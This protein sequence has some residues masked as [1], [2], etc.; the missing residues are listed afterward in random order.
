[1]VTIVPGVALLQHETQ[2]TAG[3]ECKI[4][5]QVEL[6]PG[7]DSKAVTSENVMEYIHR[8]AN[9]RLNFQIK[10]GSEAFWRGFYDLV[11]QDWVTMF[12]EEEIQMLISGGGEGLDVADMQAHV[13]YAGGYHEEHPV[14]MDFW[15]VCHA[16]S[17]SIS[18]YPHGMLN[19]LPAHSDGFEAK[20]PDHADHAVLRPANLTGLEPCSQGDLFLNSMPL[21]R[22]PL[23]T[24][25][26]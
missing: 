1:M 8:V 23:V 2:P 10:A 22:L 6:V 3:R 24:A 19:S 14:I 9:Y 17:H 21:L 16:C 18:T 7:G 26:S 12:S 15:K 11:A 20:V 25:V 13:N 5:F 4:P